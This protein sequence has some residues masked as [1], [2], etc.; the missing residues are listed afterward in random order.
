MWEAASGKVLCTLVGHGG[1][2]QSVAFSPDG[3][4]V[5]TASDDRTA[6]VWEADSG[7]ELFPLQG[8]GDSIF[9]VA[10]SPDGKLI[11]TGSRDHTAV[12]WEATSGKRLFPL[13]GHDEG[14]TSVAFAPD[15][16]RIVTGSFDKT[17]K[18]WEASNGKELL[19][20]KWHGAEVL[21]VAFSPDCKRIVTGSGD[22][23]AKV[24]ETD[25]AKELLTLKGHLGP[26]QSVGFSPD[27]QQIL[28]ASS[29]RTA[30]LWKV[31]SAD[32][33]ALWQ[34]EEAEAS[35]HL[36]ALRSERAA[37]AERE[38]ALRAQDPGAITQWLML[39]PFVYQGGDGATALAQEQVPRE[40]NLHARVG[41]RVRVGEC[42]LVWQEVHLDDY[43]IDFR[44]LYAQP[45]WSV[46]YAVCYIDSEADQSGLLMKVGSDDQSKVYL[47]GEDIYRCERNRIYIA[48]ED[49][50]PEVKLKAGLNEL[51][52]KVVNE[53]GDWLG[54][55]R[56]TDPAGRPVKGI[57]VSLSPP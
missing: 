28:T 1:A 7:K 29:D 57:H 17:A 11:V 9:A 50:V 47:N 4:R 48:D 49:V 5:A 36:A 14:V 19:T 33:V 46:A 51:V 34:R 22:H 45:K 30:K 42:E 15:G 26:V 21:A 54:S 25:N 16:R 55:I 12:V 13:K 52:F 31:A 10:F 24:W 27:G 18:V 38:R 32:Q 23:T 39:A 41:E 8:H 35:E 20:L 43:R 2:I 3:R 44:S 37:A 40:A 6:R 53:T 56:F